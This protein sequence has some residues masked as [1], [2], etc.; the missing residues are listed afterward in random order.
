MNNSLEQLPWLYVTG[1]AQHIPL[2]S[3][4]W[5]SALRTFEKLTVGGGEYK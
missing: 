3:N 4:I 2:P 5:A 1:M